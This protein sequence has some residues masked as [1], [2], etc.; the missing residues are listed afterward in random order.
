VNHLALCIQQILRMP[1]ISSNLLV[2]DVDE[3]LI[4]GAESELD[5]RADFRAGQFYI[6]RRPG[7]AEFLK[8]V[9]QWY[10][11]A[12]WSSATL[13]YVVEIAR[14]VRPAEVEWRFVWGRE[15]CTR[16]MDSERWEVEYLK[17]LKKVKQLGYDLERILFVDDTAKKVSRNYGNAI[18]V[19]PFAGSLEDSELP[20]LAKF[21]ES[22]RGVENYR[23]LEKRGWRVG[24]D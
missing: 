1:K 20:L 9:A 17:D 19:N 7:L 15:R 24:C 14:E 12:I 10:D 11:V 6:Y 5:R 18:Y 8:A 13:D 4:F 23:G 22:I 3:A 2:L 16:R 21:L